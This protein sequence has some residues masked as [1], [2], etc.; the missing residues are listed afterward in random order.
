MSSRYRDSDP[1]RVEGG[2]M[3][4]N[5]IQEIGGVIYTCLERANLGVYD[6]KGRVIEGLL[7][8]RK[9]MLGEGLEYHLFPAIHVFRPHSHWDVYHVN[10]DTE[11]TPIYQDAQPELYQWLCDCE[12]EYPPPLPYP[13]RNQEYLYSFRGTKTTHFVVGAQLVLPALGFAALVVRERRGPL[14]IDPNDRV[15]KQGAGLKQYIYIPK[16]NGKWGRWVWIGAERRYEPDPLT[17]EKEEEQALWGTLALAWGAFVG[18]KLNVVQPDA[19][20]SSPT[21]PAPGNPLVQDMVT[22]LE[23]VLVDYGPNLKHGPAQ[24]EFLLGV[25]DYFEGRA[26]S[27]R[28]H[29]ETLL[30]TFG[31]KR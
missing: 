23:Q 10:R 6:E 19:A 4:V 5:K 9:I 13:G 7:M 24:A 8:A 18:T 16:E 22:A 28:A 2:K 30:H 25:A 3:P 11:G 20:E 27:M 29:A 21:P 15:P 31:V 26:R 17:V 1:G 12:E 14:D